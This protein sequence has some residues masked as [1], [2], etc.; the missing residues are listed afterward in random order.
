MCRRY[1]AERVVREREVRG[2]RLLI[3]RSRRTKK[4]LESRNSSM[5][6]QSNDLKAKVY[7]IRAIRKVQYCFP[8]AG[9]LSSQVSA[10]DLLTRS[11]RLF[12]RMT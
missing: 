12:C 2:E 7:Q 4:G 3:L 10:V 9:T 11:V 5:R 1:R 8:E 6:R